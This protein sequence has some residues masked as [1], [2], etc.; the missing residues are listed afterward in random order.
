[1]KIPPIP[2][3]LVF[4]TILPILYPYLPSFPFLPH[5]RWPAEYANPWNSPLRL[6]DLWPTE[7]LPA[8]SLKDSRLP[9][10]QWEKWPLL[11]STTALPIYWMEF[12]TQTHLAQPAPLYLSFSHLPCVNEYY[13]CRLPHLRL[14][15]FLIQLTLETLRF[16]FCCKS[17]TCFS[18]SFSF[19]FLISLY[20]INFFHLNCAK[21][22]KWC[23]SERFQLIFS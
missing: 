9:W 18:Y 19:P 14:H 15:L 20:L 21:C 11:P 22:S 1:M 17:T 3:L 12:T 10:E 23:A 7:D 16:I 5:E 4:F 8:K 2:F 6:E 13:S